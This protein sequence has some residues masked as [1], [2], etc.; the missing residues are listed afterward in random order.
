[1]HNAKKQ[2]LSNNNKMQT[3]IK[4]NA[5]RRTGFLLL[6]TCAGI[7]GA[8]ADYP[9]G[10]YDSLEGKTGAELKKAVKAI[11][12]K[13]K[14]VISYSYGT[15]NAFLSTDVKTVDGVD[16]WWDMYS[17][18]LVRVSSGHPDMNVE[19][20]VANSWWGKTK[21]DAYKDIVHLNPSD[22]EANS[23]KSNYPLAEISGTPTWTNGVTN[24][25]K[26]VSGQGGGA[27]MVY[28]PADEYK[29]D[30][31][32]VFMYMFTAYD[33]ISWTTKTNWMYNNGT[34]L[35]FK[36]WASTLLLRWSANDPVSIKE[37][38]RNDG[39]YKEQNN[40]NPFIDLPD[41]AEYIW[42]SKSGQ[43]F[44][45]NGSGSGEDP[46]PVDP[47][48]EGQDL[49]ILW[50]AE[51]ASSMG[52]WSV[53]DVTVPSGSSYVWSWK[54]YSGKG[55][56]NA[57]A[58]ISGSAQTSLSYVW[59]PEVDLAGYT[60][61]KFSFDHAAKFQTTLRD[62][63]CVVVKETA[64]GNVTEHAIST[65]PAAGTWNFVTTQGIDLSAH[66][67]KKVRIGFKY[68][69]N[70]SGADTWE[71][72]NASLIA[73]ASGSDIET[74]IAEE[75]IDDS[76]LVEVWG[77]NIIAPEGAL[78]YDLNGRLVEGTGVQPGIYIV[79][80]PTFRRAVKIQISGK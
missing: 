70:T 71:I 28:E 60:N 21:N 67:G 18:N 68:E 10:Y 23:R 43:P 54:E 25:G 2:Q 77:N 46:E 32:R 74:S 8:S 20:S 45:I 12:L 36:S 73:K 16:Y 79:T 62:L 7:L 59:S 26:P 33:D 47:P 3:K 66:D 30:F 48:Q 14:K 29:G 34:D 78:I 1:M 37:R 4:S 58:F 53:E 40:R 31:A 50:L 6:A 69:S 15:W 65:W 17:P 56:L 72:R 49:D 44:Y 57:S 42:G 76:F 9:T 27:S 11:A 22:S 64:T 13:G 35:M 19:H 52:D 80:K 51:T 41:L 39:I 24:V 5:I 55:Y 75:D 63:C 38:T 61:T